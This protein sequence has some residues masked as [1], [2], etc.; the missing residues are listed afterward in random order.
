M[1]SGSPV[2]PADDERTGVNAF[3]RMREQLNQLSIKVGEYCGLPPTIEGERLIV[4]PTHRA[5]SVYREHNAKVAAVEGD[6]TA[7]CQ[8]INSWY[9]RRTRTDVILWLEPDGRFKWGQLPA[10]HHLAHDIRTMASSIAWSVAAETQALHK[11]Q[12]LI[13]EHLFRGYLLTG[14]FLETSKRS[15]VMYLFRRLRPT[16]ALRPNRHGEARI[17]ACLCMHPIGYYADSWAGALCP[18]DDVL[19]HLLL[20]RGDEHMFWRRSNQIPA[21]RPEAGL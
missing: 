12:E 11:L 17:L 19:T 9:S 7:Q 8:V 18:T 3:R 10:A 16:V 13:P 15:Q 5:Y 21:Y 4:E 20:M 2:A 1:P 6:D 14:M